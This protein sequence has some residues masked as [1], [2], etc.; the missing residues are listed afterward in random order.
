MLGERMNVREAGVQGAPMSGQ[1]QRG[2]PS[3]E[4]GRGSRLSDRG[5]SISDPRLLASPVINVKLSGRQKI[6]R[7]SIQKGKP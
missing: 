2:I 6:D 1:R 4:S 5:R 7:E 3:D